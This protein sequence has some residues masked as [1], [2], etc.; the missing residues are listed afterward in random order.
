LHAGGDLVAVGDVGGQEVAVT[1]TDCI[2]GLLQALLTA[3]HQQNPA[4]FGDETRRCRS[5]YIAATSGD[6][7]GFPCQLSHGV[8]SRSA[9]FRGR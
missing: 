2:A 6:D 4:S 3:R 1:G 7:G 9:R 5:A 8:G